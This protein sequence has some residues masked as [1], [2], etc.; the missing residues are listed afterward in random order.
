MR[1]E[2]WETVKHVYDEISDSDPDERVR[3]L[4]GLDAEVREEVERLLGSSDR[5]PQSTPTGFTT[6]PDHDFIARIIRDQHTFEVGQVLLNRFEI[7]RLLGSGGMGEVYE[8]HDRSLGRIAIKTLRLELTSERATIEAFRRE[9]VR[10]RS[11]RHPNVCSIYDLFETAG[12][13]EEGIPFFTMELLAG[14]TLLAAVDLRGPFAEP[15]ARAIALDLCAGL[16]AA[17]DTG[18]IHG[19]FK[20]GNVI[21]TPDSSGAIRAKIT[22]FGLARVAPWAE[23]LESIVHGPVGGTRQYMS[24]E[25]L[26]GDQPSTASDLFSLGVVLFHLRTGQYPF[27][28]DADWDKTMADRSAPPSPERLSEAME[29]NWARA[30]AACLAPRLD[31]RA[32]SAAEVAGMLTASKSAPR[33]LSRRAL[34]F[35]GVGVVAAAAAGEEIWRRGR[36]SPGLPAGPLRTIIEDFGVRGESPSLGRAARNLLHLSLA[37]YSRIELI[38][39]AE[40]EKAL[41]GIGLGGQTLREPLSKQ[42]A[43][44][45]KARV[46]VSGDV[47]IDNDHYKIG[48]RAV[49]TKSGAEI[50]SRQEIRVKLADLPTGLNRIAEKL[51]ERL[52]A[53]TQLAQAGAISV[54]QADTTRADALESFSLGLLYYQAVEQKPALENFREATRLDP[55]FAVAYA[56]ETLALLAFHE[57]DQAYEPAMKAYQLKDKLNQHHRLYVEFYY[58]FLNGDYGAAHQTLRLL[59]QLL[60]QDPNLSRQLATSYELIERPDQSL[61]W[62]R[63]AA[64]LDPASQLNENVL[65]GVLAENGLKEEAERTLFDSLKRSPDSPVLLYTKAYLHLLNL[66]CDQALAIFESLI[67]RNS[68][69]ISSRTEVV[70]ANM[71]AGRWDQAQQDL[72]RDLPVLEF[73]RE[74]PVRDLYRYWL[75]QA[76]E[77]TGDPS[78]LLEQA[79]ILSELDPKPTSLDSFH[80]AAQLA[81][82]AGKSELLETV[83]GKIRDIQQIHES[84]RAEGYWHLTAALAAHLEGD[85]AKAEA[86]IHQADRFWP[87]LTTNW[88]W[89]ELL[90]ARGVASEALIRFEKVINAKTSAIRFDAVNI[91]V[92]S[93]GRTAQCLEKLGRLSEASTYQRRFSDRWGS[94]NHY[95]FTPRIPSAAWQPLFTA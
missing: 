17:H 22:D 13:G 85:P 53:N 80:A 63:K 67:R 66:E 81:W 12:Q 28:P 21:L 95:T 7:R 89:G 26:A 55:D 25:V 37:A 10:G 8:A 9:I 56:F 3:L 71:L 30:I 82:M 70:K 34:L 68:L 44:Q 52:G 18:I 58:L 2:L 57:E 93:L 79:R 24:G 91:W 64:M 41:E 59:V 29:P 19:D 45:T 39:P 47:S 35:A 74:F 14:Q 4:A 23:P 40:V 31:E 84:T 76:A 15:E 43:A 50:L 78:T 16:Q 5:P 33:G 51:A 86:E 38:R 11:V 69:T 83:A 62:A 87:D 20:G 75:G 90:L 72:Q 92:W 88:I 65:V 32:K 48:C 1:L 27:D 6:L 54:E 94:R 77:L 60:P 36:V 42:I 61:P 46:L 73:Q 49:D